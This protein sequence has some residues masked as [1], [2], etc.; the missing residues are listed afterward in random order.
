MRYPDE[1]AEYI[2]N[3]VKGTTTRQLVAELNERFSVKYCMNFTEAKIKAYKH[4]HCLKS[5]T[6]GGAPK[7]F[8][9]VYPKGMEE[10]VRSIAKGKTSR[11]LVEAVNKKYGKDTINHTK[12]RTYMKNHKITN[13]I[14]CR[15]KKGNVPANKGAQMS[16]EQYKT[17]KGTMFKKGHKALNTMKLGEHT[18][19]TDGYV[20]KK[21]QEEGIQRE[22]FKFLHKE[23]WEKY[24]GPIPK[25][26]IV[27]FLDGNKDNCSIDNLFL[28]D[29]ATNLRLNQKKLRFNNAELTKTGIKIAELSVAVDR[30][31]KR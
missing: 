23:V 10:F 22:R 11:E 6:K 21:V 4:N 8:S 1:V 9:T 5:G 19:T 15:F 29:K 7:G 27:G 28:I 3:H 25:G 18:H 24:N 16:E 12:M 13:G 30:R 20:I 14:D 17:C 2:V 31:K 26:M